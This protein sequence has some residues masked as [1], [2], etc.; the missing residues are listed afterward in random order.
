MIIDGQ[1]HEPGPHLEWPKDTDPET[2]HAL[3]TEIVLAWMDSAGVDKALLQ[4]S[5]EWGSYASQKFPDK[6][7]F[8]PGFFAMDGGMPGDFG[9]EVKRLTD[10][11]G[12][13]GLRLI[14]GYPLT[15]ENATLFEQGAF[16]P[17]LDE[18]EKQRVPLFVFA[19]RWLPLLAPAIEAHPE[20]TLI[21]DHLGLPQPPMDEREDPPWRSLDALLELA[22]Y[23]NVAVKVCGAA[24]LSEE[25]RPFND[26]WPYLNRIIEAFGAERLMWAS[27]QSRFLGRIGFGMTLP[28][29][30]VPYPGKHTYAESVD[31]F[32]DASH[33]SD[34]DKA[35]I[36][37]GT[38]QRLLG[39]PS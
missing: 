3:L 9:A 14:V 32:R 38:L 17:L 24:A 29:A 6:F 7:A 11:P 28:N 5:V 36:L 37:G 1:L 18:C 35:M 21:V 26:V 27:D 33:L 10:I 39:W 19:T 13:K 2:Q 12:V 4:S 31:L 23:P 25:G 8:V 15:G 22:Q 30:V 34:A 20:L 16:D